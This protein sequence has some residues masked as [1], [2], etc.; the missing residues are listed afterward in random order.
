MR[1]SKNAGFSI[2]EVLIAL[3]IFMILMIPIVRGIVLALR[4]SSNSKETQYRNEFAEGVM[5]HVKAVNID[6]LL[7]ETYYT[8][9]GTVAGSYNTTSKLY[10]GYDPSNPDDSA[11]W[12]DK[13]KDNVAVLDELYGYKTYTITGEVPLGTNKTLYDYRVEI[14]S[15][16]YAERK[17]EAA[18]D[19]LKDEDDVLDPNNLALGIVEDVDY[20]KVALI[21]DQVLN[22]DSMAQTALWAKKLQNLKDKDYEAYKQE[23]E[24]K[25][26]VSVFYN[27]KGFRLMTIEVS[28]SKEDGYSVRCVV[29]YTD[30]EASLAENGEQYIEYSPYG[31]EFKNKLPDIYVMYNPCFYNGMYATDD[32]LAID[33]SGLKDDTDVNVFLV[34]IAEKYSQNIIDAN[35]ANQLADSS[36]LY[37]NNMATGGYRRDDAKIHLVGINKGTESSSNASDFLENIHVYT[38]ILDTDTSGPNKKTGSDNFLF[39]KDK[40]TK[41]PTLNGFMK[42]IN[43][44]LGVSDKKYT[45]ELY[46]NDKQASVGSLESAESES[47]GLYTVKIWMKE[48][49]ND[50][51]NDIDPTK[52]VPILEGT[53]GGNES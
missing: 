31:K 43:S 25:N 16:D 18:K 24:G 48:S 17:Y 5:E 6:Q 40:G 35:G 23:V 53:K 20:R 51:Q 4:T 22:Y 46:G 12:Y 19:P 34:E 52:D 28:G 30:S 29:H 14:S 2:V 1:K 33:T 50:N 39:A 11:F 10:E 15:K 32:Y 44:S 3:A 9:M 36:A 47:R 45:M 27:D 13:N 21:D 8:N 7:D 26:G 38:N 49:K 37:N 42:Y 41:D